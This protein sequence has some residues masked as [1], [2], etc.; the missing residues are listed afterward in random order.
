MIT[1]Q[2]LFTTKLHET[3][4]LSRPSFWAPS[5]QPLHKVVLQLKRALAVNAYSWS[6]QSGCLVL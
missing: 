3:V 2:S 1:Y 4:N 5:Q 6:L